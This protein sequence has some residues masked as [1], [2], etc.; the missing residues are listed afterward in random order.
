[1]SSCKQLLVGVAL[2]W[3]GATLTLPAAAQGDWIAGLS[4]ADVVLLGEI[5]DNPDHHLRQAEAVTALSPTAVVFEMLSPEQADA[6]AD[7]VLNS[8]SQMAELLGWEA[9]GWP[10]YAM[11]HPIFIAA[12]GAAIYGA[13]LP[14]AQIRAA[15][16]GDITAIFGE[17]ADKFG[18]DQPLNAAEQE[19]REAMQ[20]SAH[21]DALP[22][23][24]LPGMVAAQRLR[25]AH[26]SRVT[27]QALVETGGPVAVITGNG[28]ARKD[29]GM[30]VYLAAAASDVTVRALGQ[31]E[32]A[33]APDAPFDVTLT[34]SA[35]ER[36]DPC[37][38]FR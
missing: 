38:A 2:A 22:E 3:A 18:L 6:L 17:A 7:G 32:D 19:A 13:A 37:L 28:H 33:P 5:H 34:S 35:A 21:C 11:Y 16:S 26:F 1:M 20:M 23:D 30:P 15:V 27:L 10:D 24:M 12:Q 25:D 9:S 4:D 36:T 8:A 31:F 29:W 14:R